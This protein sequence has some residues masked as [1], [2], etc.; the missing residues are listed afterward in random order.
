MMPENCTLYDLHF[1]ETRI[2]FF[3]KKGGGGGGCGGGGEV[4]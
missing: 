2:L 1:K 3:K 4:S